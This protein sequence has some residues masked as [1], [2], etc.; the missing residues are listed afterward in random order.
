MLVSYAMERLM[1]LEGDAEPSYGELRER[2]RP[3]L[4]W[5]EEDGRLGG[6]PLLALFYPCVTLAKK[7]DPLA[8]AQA[9]HDRLTRVEL[10][11]RVSKEIAELLSPIIRAHQD[12]SAR[13]DQRWY[14]AAP[15]LL[16]KTYAAGVRE[17][18]AEDSDEWSWGSAEDE[19]QSI[20]QRHIA[21]AARIL[22][23]PQRLGR[24]PDDLTDAL[25]KISLGAP[26]TVVLRSLLRHSPSSD[27]RAA[28]QS[29]APAALGFRTLFNVPESVLLLRRLFARQMP[30]WDQVLNYCCDGNLQAVIDE[31]VHVLIDLLSVEP[32][33]AEGLHSLG[34]AIG[35]AVSL[36]TTSLACDIY[37]A[38]SSGGFSVQCSSGLSRSPRQYAF[39]S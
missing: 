33:S 8:H 11:R 9:Q 12:K 7:I 21:E 16:D 2:H 5:S 14:W 29:A 24:P 32:D 15:L 37:R 10:E 31:Y 30:Y 4:R 22:D 3:L 23:Q 26:G 1:V 28:W 38:S 19:D 35:D 36:H 25:T 34:D 27:D 6:M 39:S 20:F 13:P 18:M 17:W